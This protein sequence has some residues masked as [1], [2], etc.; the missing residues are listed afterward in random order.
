MPLVLTW[1]VV[2]HLKKKRIDTRLCAVSAQP[3]PPSQNGPNPIGREALYVNSSRLAAAAA[4]A[5]RAHTDKRVP[6]LGSPTPLWRRALPW[7][8]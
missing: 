7:R 6:A 2:L 3:S 1:N 4:T 5:F 8:P